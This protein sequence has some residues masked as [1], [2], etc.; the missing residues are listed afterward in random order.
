MTQIPDGPG[1]VG[2]RADSRVSVAIGSALAVVKRL[3][4]ADEESARGFVVLYVFPFYAGALVLN[5][6]LPAPAMWGLEFW[7]RAGFLAGLMLAPLTGYMRVTRPRRALL[8]RL[9][10]R[11]EAASATGAANWSAY[12]PGSSP[13]EAI[14]DTIRMA[15]GATQLATEAG[16]PTITR[17]GRG[18][19]AAVLG[20]LFFATGFVIGAKQGMWSVAVAAMVGVGVSVPLALW[21]GL[22]WRA[23]SRVRAEWASN[24]AEALADI[25]RRFEAQWGVK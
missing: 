24:I 16:A 13:A 19:N 8:A 21:F 10:A 20:A 25:D 1:P 22:Q 11:L 17:P 14:V 2:S 12:D 4:A 15:P 23:S 3:Q 6:A 18:F 7:L 5:M 9:A